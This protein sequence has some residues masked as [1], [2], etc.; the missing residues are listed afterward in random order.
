[1]LFKK[2]FQC[3]CGKDWNL[4][5]RGLLQQVHT[6]PEAE[7]GENRQASAGELDSGHFWTS[8]Q[9]ERQEEVHGPI[10]GD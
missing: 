2:K 10:Q 1:M 7:D 5:G 3:W 4:H 6:E 9:H 8:P